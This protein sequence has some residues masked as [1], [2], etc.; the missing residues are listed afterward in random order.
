MKVST[1][2]EG[3]SHNGQLFLSGAGVQYQN[4]IY[5]PVL[6]HAYFEKQLHSLTNEI[7]SRSVIVGSVQAT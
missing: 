2:L 6:F 3:S 7:P 1:L 5:N 4:S